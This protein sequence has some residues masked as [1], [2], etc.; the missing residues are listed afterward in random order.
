MTLT[1]RLTL[2][3]AATIATIAVLAG[4]YVQALSLALPAHFV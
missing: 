3:A 1:A 4:S 2:A